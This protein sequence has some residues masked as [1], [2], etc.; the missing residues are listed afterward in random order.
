MPSVKFAFSR[1]A[2]LAVCALSLIGCRPLY[3][4]F[5][6]PKGPPDYQLGWEDGCDTS[7]SRGD[8]TYRLT[9]GFKKREE[10]LENQLYNAGWQNGLLFCTWPNP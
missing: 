3:S 5:D 9:Y 6:N 2:L 1:I 8:G 10:L 7:L 4:Y